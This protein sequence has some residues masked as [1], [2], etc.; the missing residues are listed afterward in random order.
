MSNNQLMVAPI[1]RLA[2]R[3][4]AQMVEALGRMGFE[5]KNQ[6]GRVF[7][8]VFNQ[9]SLYGDQYAVYQVD[10]ER[11]WH[12]S[13]ADLANRRVVEQLS[14]VVR[15][16]VRALNSGGLFY[17]VYLRPVERA[18][19]PGVVELDLDA[20]PAGDLVVPLGVGRDGPVWRELRQIGH[21]L[22]VGATGSGKS[23]FIHAVIAALT[24]QAGPDRL[25]LMLVDPK[26]SEFAAW[27]GLPHL[28]GGIAHSDAEAAA[29][30]LA[31]VD[32]C[33]RRGELLAAARARDIESYNKRCDN[34][35]PYIMVIVDECLNLA[36]DG[37]RDVLAGLRTLA[38][39]GRSAGV[40][41]WAATQHASAVSG[42]PRVVNAN[43]ASRFV[44]RVLDGNAARTAGCPG[45]QDL[46]RGCPGRML[47]SLGERPVELQAY[48]CGDDLIGAP[49]V[50]G[51]RPP[52]S[53]EERALVKV[54]MEQLGGAFI[55]N[56]LASIANGWSSHRVKILA[57]KWERCG[58]LT[59]P[60][61]RADARHVTEALLELVRG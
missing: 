59:K 10:A 45:A 9:I 6:D 58:W 46:P 54:A 23:S 15:R 21:A 61:H 12:F 39:R 60:A 13:V 28:A 49:G 16:R 51:I 44:F 48:H 47:A 3:M 1:A 41:L 32:E 17:V 20:R 25:R 53:D 8:P 14:A 42:L 37:R 56:R 19:L 5:H 2:Q 4:G 22:V 29:M 55:V 33:D 34:A 30:L 11:L 40:Y 31:A 38:V 43:L 26:R 57:Q 18:P 52:I 36:M 35:L 7:R 50:V 24:S 27:A